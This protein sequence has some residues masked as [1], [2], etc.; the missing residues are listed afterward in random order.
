MAEEFPSL[1]RAQALQY[2]IMRPVTAQDFYFFD[3]V[4][5]SE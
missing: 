2:S 1:V 4:D 3:D 5:P